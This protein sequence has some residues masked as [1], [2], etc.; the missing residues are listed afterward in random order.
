LNR[1]DNKQVV[2]EFIS[3]VCADDVTIFAGDEDIS[4]EESGLID[5]LSMLEIVAFLEK[6]F[7]IDFS[8][9]GIDADDVGS[10]AKILD[11]IES[12][13]VRRQQ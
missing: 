11:L 2:L 12:S 9:T 5:S 10:I 1:S 3:T 8:K 7:F 4:F 13:G 6:Q